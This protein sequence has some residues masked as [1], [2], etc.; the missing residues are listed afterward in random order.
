MCHATGQRH[1][2]NRG[3]RAG[4]PRVSSNPR[5]ALE[6]LNSGVEVGQKKGHLGTFY[7]DHKVSDNI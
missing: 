5:E 4:K 2:R 1:P 7:R 6:L 3:L